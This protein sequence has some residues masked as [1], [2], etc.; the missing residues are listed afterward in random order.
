[1]GNKRL[2][3][4]IAATVCVFCSPDTLFYFPFFFLGQFSLLTHGFWSYG[5]LAHT[6][7]W[8]TPLSPVCLS[9]KWPQSSTPSHIYTIV[10]IFFSHSWKI[11]LLTQL[12]LL[13]GSLWIKSAISGGGLRCF[14]SH[15][16]GRLNEKEKSGI[17]GKMWVHCILS[18]QA[19]PLFL[20]YWKKYERNFMSSQIS[21]LLLISI[22]LLISISQLL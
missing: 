8:L 19:Y 16:W 13:I 15:T 5:M 20:A 10:S 11:T 6:W 2:S 17:P 12:C 3:R 4:T 18:V 9:I 21:D 22:R 7:H 14:R 1:M